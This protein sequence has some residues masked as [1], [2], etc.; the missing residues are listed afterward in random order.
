MDMSESSEEDVWDDEEWDDDKQ[1]TTPAM[2]TSTTKTGSHL[3]PTSQF[4]YNYF[5]HNV[6]RYILFIL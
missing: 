1:T 2:M 4:F 3:H 5:L 6:R